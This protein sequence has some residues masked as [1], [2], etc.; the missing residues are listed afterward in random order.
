[1]KMEKKYYE[2]LTQN[3]KNFV[4]QISYLI[5]NQLT[6]ARDFEEYDVDETINTLA[7]NS[8]FGMGKSFF[9]KGLKHYIENE[10]LK[11]SYLENIQVIDY[12]AWE[13]DFFQEPMKTI[14]YRILS[15]VSNGAKTEIELTESLEKILNTCGETVGDIAQI[16]LFKIL[17][18]LKNS[19][20]IDSMEEYTDYLELIEK[21]KKVLE[22]N[23]ILFDNKYTPK[24]IIIDE[25]DRCRP[26]FSIE[27][28]ECVKHFFN[29]RG[30]FFVFLINKEQLTK[31]AE[32]LFGSFG[33]KE[34]YFQ[35]FFDLEFELPKLEFNEYLEIEY[36][37]HIDKSKYLL[38]VENE[39]EVDI[40][41]FSEALFLH[42]YKN[43]EHLLDSSV[44]EFKKKFSKFKMLI[45]TLNSREREDLTMLLTLVLYYINKEFSKERFVEFIKKV[46]ECFEEN[47]SLGWDSPV[48]Y[49]KQIELFK[50]IINLRVDKWYYQ[51]FFRCI[52][53][54]NFNTRDD[55]GR[56]YEGRIKLISLNDQNIAY[57]ESV[58]IGE[59]SLMN[60]D[61]YIDER[62]NIGIPLNI[63][64]SYKGG[65][66]P[67]IEWCE[68]KYSFLE[69]L[70]ISE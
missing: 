58:K 6:D 63:S 25:L 33:S 43:L 35:K 27:V 8:T 3:R 56:A 39:Y 15:G 31:S 5:I 69:A 14:L 4:E 24:V 2:G 22:D 10:A 40:N 53:N 9:A 13:N 1:M 45:K 59:M 66:E 20:K 64:P 29:I 21:T 62:A 65:N 23:S 50:G 34:S 18:I 67:L 49:G 44:R 28:L 26:D 46:R 70:Y 37:G 52:E 48:Y 57:K 19:D 42:F 41:V 54:F 30:L 17:K 7:I 12:N 60:F 55:Y 47:S 68:K 61:Y 51:V 32:N 36:K 11:N 16:P 38:I